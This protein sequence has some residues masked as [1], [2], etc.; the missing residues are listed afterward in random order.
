MECAFGRA[1]ID[2]FLFLRTFLSIKAVAELLE[3]LLCDSRSESLQEK[4]PA[5]LDRGNAHLVNMP[6]NRHLNA[7][8]NGSRYLQV[9]LID[10][11]AI[12]HFL[13]ARCHYVVQPVL[14]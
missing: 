8:P 1:V 13:L 9:W 11:L 3:V 7:V 12:C 2:K 5:Y 6:D 10:I 4:L 14:T